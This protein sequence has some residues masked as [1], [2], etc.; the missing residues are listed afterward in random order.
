MTHNVNFGHP[1][2]KGM[3]KIADADVNT[4]RTLSYRSG[5]NVL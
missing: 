4:I 1:N 3:V 2:D 5:L